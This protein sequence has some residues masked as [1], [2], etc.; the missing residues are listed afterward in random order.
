MPAAEWIQ[1][2]LGSIALLGVVAAFSTAYLTWRSRAILLATKEKHSDDLKAVLEQWKG[3]SVQMYTTFDPAYPY[4]PPPNKFP[5]EQVVLFSDLKNHLPKELR[6]MATWDDFKKKWLEVEAQEVSYQQSVRASLEHYTGLQALTL[7]DEGKQNSGITRLCVGTW[8]SY[9]I[10]LAR[11]GK[12]P[13]INLEVVPEHNPTQVVGINSGAW[14]ISPKAS[15]VRDSLLQMV[16]DLRNQRYDS[17]IYDLLQKG[18]TVVRV[19]DEMESLKEILS[20][21][22]EEAKAIPILTGNCKHIRRA[23]E[24]LFPWQRRG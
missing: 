22:I 18:K 12:I 20:N 24:P 3:E 21:R 15:Q 14:V 8:Y 11:Y 10:S 4:S 17:V 2:I 1:V 13:T 6:L 9:M 16:S 5:I 19:Q 23:T 7:D